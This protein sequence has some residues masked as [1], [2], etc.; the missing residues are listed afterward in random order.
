MLVSLIVQ[1]F[2]RLMLTLSWASELACWKLMDIK[3]DGFFKSHYVVPR[4]FRT[5]LEPSSGFTKSS[6][7]T[8]SCFGPFNVSYFSC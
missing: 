5:K 6:N 3:G 4:D 8:E 7:G 2:D 1:M